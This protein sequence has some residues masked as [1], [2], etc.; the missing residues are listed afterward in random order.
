MRLK[1]ALER[2][3]HNTSCS[4]CMETW[5][6]SEMCEMNNLRLRIHRLKLEGEE[7]AEYGPAREPTKVGVDEV[8]EGDQGPNFRA[9]PTARRTGHGTPRLNNRITTR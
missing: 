5:Q 1:R 8:P 3:P 7:L 6:V 4:N 2:V 9:D